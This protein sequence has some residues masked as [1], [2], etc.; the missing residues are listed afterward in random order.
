MLLEAWF[1]SL[2]LKLEELAEMNEVD[3]GGVES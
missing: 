2:V 3:T 1:S